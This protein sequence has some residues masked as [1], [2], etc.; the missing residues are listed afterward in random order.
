MNINVENRQAI[1]DALKRELVGPAPDGSPLDLQKLSFEKWEDAF[2]PFVDKDTGEE[3]IRRDRPS[4]RYGVA[5][6]HP[7]ATPVDN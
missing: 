2:G 7:Y 3:I 5:V 1:I 4:N 6:L